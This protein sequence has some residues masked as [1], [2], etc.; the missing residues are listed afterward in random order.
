M[1]AT[2]SKITE[3][4]TNLPLSSK[5]IWGIMALVFIISILRPLP[6]REGSGVGAGVVT[7]IAAAAF[8]SDSKWLHDLK[9]IEPYILIPVGIVAV[10]GGIFLLGMIIV[11]SEFLISKKRLR[12]LGALVRII[13]VAGITAIAFLMILSVG[14][15]GAIYF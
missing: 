10:L 7:G 9:Y 6:T 4:F 1:S 3:F 2:V 12:F 13:G 11:L 5:I 8:L 14:N 15:A